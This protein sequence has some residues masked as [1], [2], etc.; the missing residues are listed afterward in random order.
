[1]PQKLLIIDDS[2]A[3]H[4]LVKARLACEPVDILSAH[5]GEVGA[6]MARDAAPDT[7]LLDVEMPFPVGFEVCRRLQADPATSSIPIIFLTGASTTEEKVR[8]L[9]L[10]AVDY[11]TKPFDPAELRARVRASLRTKYLL[12]LLAKKAQ[13]DAM[14]GLW[15]RAHF[16]QRLATELS[17]AERKGYTFSIVL[18]DVDHFKSIND[19]YGHPCGDA[20]L[21]MVA[22]VLVD[23]HRLEDI[24]CRYGGEE[25]VMLLPATS[26][27]SAVTVAERSRARIADSV[28]PHG[29]DRIQV[30][31]SFGIAST[32]E[33]TGAEVV[34]QADQ[35]LYAAKRAGRDRVEV[36]RDCDY[37][38]KPPMATHSR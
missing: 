23:S 8:G 25:F 5:S 38:G 14:T 31:C 29:Q 19:R 15:N 2:K 9:E 35:A 11:I 6:A 27:D 37:D 24:V 26:S 18:A 28:L 16:E 30:T 12:D 1:M 36:S 13:I 22:Q 32:E 33:G 10:G 21:R 34:R 7:I 3:V 4:A 17:L 20:V